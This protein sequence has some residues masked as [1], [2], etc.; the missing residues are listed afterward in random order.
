MKHSQLSTRIIDHTDE[1]DTLQQ[2]HKSFYE[3]NQDL[4]LFR[5]KNKSKVFSI[6]ENCNHREPLKTKINFTYLNW[7][8]MDAM[9]K[10]HH[11]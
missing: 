7:F 1:I 2:L 9:L 4:K 10:N 6:E 11:D 3:Y 5:Q 8:R